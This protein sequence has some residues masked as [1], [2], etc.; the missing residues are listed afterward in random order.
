MSVINRF[1]I[2]NALNL[3]NQSP[4]S[5]DWEPH[6]RA[7]VIEPAGVN[8]AI[9]LPNGEGKSSFNN[10]Y[11]GVLLRRKDF[12]RKL[13]SILAPK[14]QGQYSHFRI[15][16]TYDT[17]HGR[18]RQLIGATVEGERYVFGVYGYTDDTLHFYH[19]R[20]TLEDLPV[21][22]TQGT[23]VRLATNREFDERRKQL[24]ML[25]DPTASVEAWLEKVYLHLDRHTLEKGADYQARGG[26]DGADTLFNLKTPAGTNY[27]TEFFYRYLAPEIL[28][29]C[30]RTFGDK[31]EHRFEDT[32][33]KSARPLVMNELSLT[34][35]EREVGDFN[36]VHARLERGTEY[37]GQYAGAR[38]ERL[39]LAAAHVAETRWLR[40]IVL[41]Q[42]LPG[43]PQPVS[44]RG[45]Q[46][47][48][49]ADRLV[50]DG[51]EWLVPDSL[52]AELLDEEPKE[53]NRRADRLGLVKRPLTQVV[54][55]PCHL[56]FSKRD[57]GHP[58]QGYGC[59]AALALAAKAPRAAD[60][61]SADGIVRAIRYAFEERE[62]PSECNPLRA[63]W[64]AA[65]QAEVV[66]RAARADAKGRRTQ[67]SEEA[68]RLDT[69]LKS[70]EANEAALQ[71]MENSGQFSAEELQRPVATKNAIQAA[72]RE[73]ETQSHAL[74]S[75][76]AELAPARDAF[77]AVAAHFGNT[78]NPDDLQRHLADEVTVSRQTLE[79][80]ERNRS[81][82]NQAS[83]AASLSAQ[84]E[85]RAGQELQRQHLKL[86]R[87]RP[88]ALAFSER[89]GT[90][91]WRGVRESTL[92]QRDIANQ[93][94]QRITQQLADARAECG[95]L[96]DLA[97]R[98]QDYSAYFGDASPEGLDLQVRADYT[99][100]QRQRA[101]VG[102]T[103][104]ALEQRLAALVEGQRARDS[105]AVIFPGR[106]VDTL[107]QDLADEQQALTAEIARRR[108]LM[109]DLDAAVAAWDAFEAHHGVGASARDVR[110]ARRAKWL[111]CHTR[112]TALRDHMEALLAQVGELKSAGTAAGPLARQV[113]A[114]LARQSDPLPPALH[115]VVRELR[116]G[117]QRT[118]EVLSLFSQV[119]HAPVVSSRDEAQQVLARLEAAQLDYPVFHR[120]GL[121]AVCRES[122]LS[123]DA[124]H[125]TALLCGHRSLV[126][127][128]LLDPRRIT[129]RIVD[130]ETKA[131]TAEDAMATLVGERE[132][133]S[134]TSAAGQAIIAA[135]RAQTMD[136]R[137]RHS[138]NAVGL[139]DAQT[140]QAALVNTLTPDFV[141]CLRAAAH[142]QAEGAE[143]ARDAT[144]LDLD[145]A[146]AEQTALEAA[147]PSVQQRF[148]RVALILA[149]QAF[150]SAGGAP[151][152]DAL[153]HQV[154]D[155]GAA[156]DE[157]QRLLARY[158]D[159]M[160]H[161][162][163][164]DRAAEYDALG[165]ETRFDNAQEEVATATQ[166]LVEAQEHAAAEHARLATA[167]EAWQHADARHRDAQQHWARWE[168]DLLRAVGYVA[169][170][171][172]AFDAAYEPNLTRWQAQTHRQTGR[173]S[174]NF[175]GAEAGAR[176]RE[177]VEHEDT[178][179]SRHVEVRTELAALERT[180][181]R[182]ED[183]I[184][185][186]RTQSGELKELS[187]RIDVA[188]A[189]LLRHWDT[190][191]A[192]ERGLDADTLAA[193]DTSTLPPRVR[194][195]QQLREE[196][197]SASS[198]PATLAT[199]VEDICS[200]VAGFD[201]HKGDQR[202]R[203]L[204]RAEE[205]ALREACRLA[206][207][208]VRDPSAKLSE[209]ERMELDP[210]VRERA[211]VA[212]NLLHLETLFR[213]FL[214][215]A[216]RQ[217]EE[218]K[219]DIASARERFHASMAGFAKAIPENLRLM[220]QCLKPSNELASA[221]LLLDVDVAGDEAIHQA[222]HLV[223]DYIRQHV[224]EQ[225]AREKR[226]LVTRAGA[227][228]E[229]LRDE[230]GQAFFRTIFRGAPGSSAGPVVKLQH[231][232]IA[233]G[234]ARPLTPKLSVGQKNAVFLMIM[235]KL[236]DFAQEQQLHQD[237]RPSTQVKRKVRSSR[238]L[239]IDGLF[240]NLSKRSLITPSLEAIKEL[241]GNFQLIGWIHNPSY[242][243]DALL[244]PSYVTLRRYGREHGFVAKHQEFVAGE[245][246]PLAMR[247][248]QLPPTP[249]MPL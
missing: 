115:E 146:I 238:V 201:V 222:T 84:A 198:D 172:P 113:R 118:E 26:G 209:L 51:A 148:D 161:L 190:A 109:E 212:Q 19:Y 92:A 234:K 56:T 10:A 137:T 243:N 153:D 36:R 141:S 49:V 16:F 76:R 45:K 205:R 166:R 139:A 32:L 18:Q 42:P 221:G 78:S 22:A 226:S 90:R 120:P 194:A 165:G 196:L 244:F 233:L 95:H 130:L 174:F 183:E 197:P 152:R 208:L 23:K 248:T 83:H 160:E 86:Q 63:R 202:L 68:T 30:M 150:L 169:A 64:R 89:F 129:A 225:R 191:A 245:M 158:V 13:K 93:S 192:I 140:R 108:A 127:E 185:E 167:Q 154:L 98:A 156:L 193:I 97:R 48:F 136:A 33:L 58:N 163:L 125:A 106:C 117:E 15:E 249:S 99:R 20:G 219:R 8:T 66:A 231:P 138:T 62:G 27:D 52:L 101:D 135:E 54:E 162:H 182:L 180:L 223:A 119:L 60:G 59:D 104:E 232:S 151:R 102:R 110:E 11:Y 213:E 188:V 124:G 2:V 105:V 181:N 184:E 204:Q 47:R 37:V 122:S 246:V 176:L 91:E 40:S 85:E 80:A 7:V 235:V 239:M 21:Q 126:V 75:R 132:A 100:V 74:T 171:G 88:L 157:A 53:M 242:E 31:D 218:L 70:L 43:V 123:L 214:G 210:N 177:N 236:A 103:R 200:N 164:V 240:S 72:L 215:R 94:V 35:K 14:R 5:A 187:R 82:V 179:R 175:E 65:A 247:L 6:W 71:A 28:V 220:K 186:H 1:E 168:R 61:W 211:Q 159:L 9:K 29:G 121:E 96:D 230:I 44:N 55:N 207:E 178:L 112:E 227:R 189:G 237:G 228:E 229:E 57:R 3:D 206:E 50:V 203:D 17:H 173:L 114:A 133:L 38:E 147:W 199:L 46:T 39:S 87:L 12:V 69:S 34:D 25:C 216:N 67:L 195:A 81:E 143:A 4:G 116:L 142:F 79:D 145:E 77:A 149:Q 134:E 144:R 41:E 155:D 128:L 170:D 131:K 24:T 224:E 73:A 107:E 111:E 241:R 217:V